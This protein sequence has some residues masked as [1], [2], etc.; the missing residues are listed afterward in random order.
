MHGERVKQNL[1]LHTR[2]FIST[3][4]TKW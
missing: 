2:L 1:Y 4:E 3:H